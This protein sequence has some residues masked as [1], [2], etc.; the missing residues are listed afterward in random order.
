MEHAHYLQLKNEVLRH[1]RL[2]YVE[3]AP[4][5]S[6]AAYD[7]L[8]R[9]LQAAETAHPEWVEPDSPTQRVGG[10]PLQAFQSVA[11]AQ[12]VLSLDNSLN[13]QEA[14]AFVQRLREEVGHGQE[15]ELTG[16]LK[17]DGLAICLVYAKGWF[18]QAVT[19]G[20]GTT[21]E[22]V[23]EQ[24]R[25]IQNV[26]M[27]VA[28]EAPR[29]EVRGEVLMP[30]KV[31]HALNAKL[32]KPFVNPRNAAA[33][34]LRQLDPRATAQRR[35]SFQ[36]YG[37]GACEGVALPSRHSERMQWVQ[38]LGFQTEGYLGTLTTEKLQ[39]AFEGVAQRRQSLPFGIDG[40]VFKVDDIALQEA[41]G[42]NSR[43]P[44]W[45]TAYKFPPEEAVTKLRHIDTQVGRTGVITPVAKIEPVFVGGV[46]VSSVTLHNTDEIERLGVYLGDFVVVRRAGDVIPEIAQ[47]QH[48]LRPADAQ[49]FVMPSHCPSCGSQLQRK[50]VAW[51]CMAGWDCEGQR[52]ERIVHFASRLG[53][54]IEGLGPGKVKKLLEAGLV[55][56]PESLYA[57]RAQDLQG[58]E[59]F[60]TKSA[61]SLLKAV[62]ATK[63]LKLDRFIYSLGIEDVGS[64]LSK[65]LAEVFQSWDALFQASEEALRAVPDI[66]EVTARSLREG[67][68]DPSTA[69]LA[70]IIGPTWQQV[71]GELKGLTVVMTGT[72][73][74]PRPKLKEQL[75]GQGVRV[76][77]SVSARVDVLIAGEEAG[78][79]LA[80]ARKLGVQVLQESDLEAQVATPQGWESLLTGLR[81]AHAQKLQAAA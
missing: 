66:G 2:Y 62:E 31:F 68:S 15:V 10:A 34:S 41:L 75:Q 58:L 46:T 48:S 7:S 44:R 18:R 30:T 74:V 3:D 80:K 49:P 72:L 73:S 25:T 24:V 17:Y 23:T 19:R 56:R 27:R 45:A 69:V 59:G 55:E 63:G 77:D 11:H 65:A 22:D 47:V 37:L 60:G 6:D 61:Q 20:D 4:E 53:A 57:L 54:D 38:S 67:L 51:R 71:Q 39:E 52:L 36:A 81:R 13:E 43:T 8:F 14:Q 9:Q 78:D 40:V 28:C 35:L 76:S 32:S 5:I 16:E 70:G 21:G 26:P 42:W 79:K 33:G 29:L 64:T 1:S 50:D 12:P